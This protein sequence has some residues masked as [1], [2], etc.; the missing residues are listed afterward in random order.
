MAENKIL[1][2]LD[3]AVADLAV[4]YV[5]LHNWHWRVKGIH[6]KVI[7]GVTERYY[8]HVTELYD[9]AAER[10]L[11]KGGNP[12]GSLRGYLEKAH[13]KEIEG[14][15]FDAAQVIDGILEDF[16][17]LLGH[18]NRIA[19]LASEANDKATE[20]LAVE[21]IAWFEKEIWM[22]RASRP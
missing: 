19:D 15:S 21:A 20:D 5:K 6:F 17:H 7:H 13:I 14:E 4:L 22:L 10:M 16:K 12:T 2:E 18:F 1:E 9:D 11:Q 8:E 3:V